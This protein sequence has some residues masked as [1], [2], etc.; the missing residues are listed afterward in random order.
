M[1][2]RMNLRSDPHAHEGTAWWRAGTQAPRDATALVK[3]GVAG[4]YLSG[5]AQPVASTPY[6]LDI[7]F[8]ARRLR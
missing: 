6:G 5:A 7:A 3:V 2:A 8:A 4:G 1:S